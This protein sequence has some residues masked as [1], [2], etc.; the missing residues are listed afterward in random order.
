MP[1]KT[2]QIFLPTGDPRGVSVGEITTRIVRV[3]EVAHS[4]LADL[5]KMLEAQQ[6]GFTSWC[7][8]GLTL[9]CH[10]SILASV[11]CPERIQTDRVAL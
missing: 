1:P 3:T 11:V 2:I 5:L 4:K 6:S 8:S 7:A 10:A 9:V